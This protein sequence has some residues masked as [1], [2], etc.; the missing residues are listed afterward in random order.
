MT[1]QFGLAEIHEVELKILKDIDVLCREH[2]IEYYLYCGTL[3]GSVRH[4]GFIPWDDD[5][6]IMMPLKDYRR[7]FKIAQKEMRDRYSICEIHNDAYAMV[8]WTQ[9]RM[10]GTAY[11][12]KEHENIRYHK[13]FSLD[14]Y[15]MIGAYDGFLGKM[16][17]FAIDFQRNLTGRGLRK[18]ENYKNVR[19]FEAARRM[20]DRLPRSV[21]L[22]MNDIVESVF[23]PDPEK[24]ERCG[25]VD[26]VVFN[27]KYVTRDWDERIEGEFEGC[28]FPIPA[29]YDLFLRTMYGDYM[30]L[31]PEEK[32]KGHHVEGSVIQI[33]DR[34][35]KETGIDL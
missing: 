24:H 12:P 23:W 1:S 7:F 25:T 6:D 29:K 27:G 20:V 11:Y 31:P 10:N 32:R 21:L 8:P 2:E 30:K 16:Q 35:A 17:R 19:R 15:P 33:S 26:A 9:V 34:V 13:G 4:K 5:I 28:R 22:L 14:V 18:A 3:L